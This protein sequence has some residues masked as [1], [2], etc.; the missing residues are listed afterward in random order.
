MT[1]EITFVAPAPAG[2]YQI[3]IIAPDTVAG[4]LSLTTS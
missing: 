4:P 1:G 2:T 3:S